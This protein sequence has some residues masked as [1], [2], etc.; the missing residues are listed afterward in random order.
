MMTLPVGVPALDVTRTDTVT[1]LPLTE[2]SGESAVMIV[3]VP[4]GGGGGAAVT[5]CG[6]VSELPVRPDPPAYVAVR[7]RSP[8]V[9]N[10]SWQLPAPPDKAPEQL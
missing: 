3:V 1:L 4:A 5:V 2:G 10:E 8:T 6:S 9:D 7:V